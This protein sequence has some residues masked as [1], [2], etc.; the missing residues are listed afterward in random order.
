MGCVVTKEKRAI[1]VRGPTSLSGIDADMTRM[2]DTAQTLATIAACAT[3][4]TTMTGLATLR[5]KETD[6]ISAL[7]TELK[8]IGIDSTTGPESLTVMG[9][10]PH[11]GRIATYED[12]RMAM[13][14]AL[15]AARLNGMQIEHPEVVEKSFPS[16]WCTLETLGVKSALE[17]TNE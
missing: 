3:G 9:G 13:S 10:T 8:K 17:D 11:G 6:R 15:L 2:P 1:T 4:S 5:V 14:F 16:F 12:H 7:H